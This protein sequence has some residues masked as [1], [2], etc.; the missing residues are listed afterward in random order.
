MPA[1]DNFRDMP[2]ERLKLRPIPLTTIN[3]DPKDELN[4]LPF[5]HRARADPVMW[6]PVR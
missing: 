3:I 6:R 4:V 5:E 2:V 1:S